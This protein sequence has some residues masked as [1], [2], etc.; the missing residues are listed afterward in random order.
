MGTRNRQLHFFEGFHGTPHAEDAEAIVKSGFDLSKTGDDGFDSGE[1]VYLTSD[2][3][4]A[5]EHAFGMG[6]DEYSDDDDLQRA[7][8][9]RVLPV[10][11]KAERP[12]TEAGNGALERHP[13]HVQEL[14]KR[15]AHNDGADPKHAY[16]YVP[17]ALRSLGHDA[18]IQGSLAVAF[19]PQ[20]VEVTGA[21]QTYRDVYGRDP[22][23]E[24]WNVKEGR[25]W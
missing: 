16:T 14:A 15:M 8:S 23:E 25:N 1:G 18:W 3:G 6:F 4:W 10:R 7:K 19:H 9:G 20:N 22:E 13:V 11:L 2:R 17:Q 21:P 24:L 5:A 12:Y